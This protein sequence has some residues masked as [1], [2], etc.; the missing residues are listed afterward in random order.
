MTNLLA[1]GGAHVASP[2]AIMCG[3]CGIVSVR[4]A[5]CGDDR[6]S[7]MVGALAHRGGRIACSDWHLRFARRRAYH[8]RPTD[9]QP[10]VARETGVTAVYNGEIDDHQASRLA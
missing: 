3:V 2:G 9:T 7:A 1:V 10:I 6:T 8:P 5:G 4:A